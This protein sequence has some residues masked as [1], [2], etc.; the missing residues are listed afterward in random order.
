[1]VKFFETLKEF[2]SYDEEVFPCELVVSSNIMFSMILRKESSLPL[3]LMIVIVMNFRNS[4]LLSAVVHIYITNIK[5]LSCINSKVGVCPW[6]LSSV[7]EAFANA[8][9]R[10]QR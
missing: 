1:M 5:P 3:N 7:G 6:S 8:H 2:I 9:R 10:I 4:K